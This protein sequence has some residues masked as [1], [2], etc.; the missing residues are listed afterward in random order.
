M[1]MENNQGTELEE[2]NDYL[3]KSL[4]DLHEGTKS[5]GFQKYFSQTQTKL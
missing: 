1:E 3:K 2:N 5:N 4:Y